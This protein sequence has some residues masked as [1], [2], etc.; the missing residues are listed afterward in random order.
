M[1]KPS[2]LAKVALLLMNDG[3]WEGKQIYPAWYIKEATSLQT[4]TLVK[5]HTLEEQQGY[6]YQFWRIRN[7]NGYMCYGK[8]GQLM[9]CCPKYDFICVTTAD[10][11]D[12]QG[13]TQLI[14]DS[15]FECILERPDAGGKR[16]FPDAKPPFIRPLSDIG[17]TGD[18]ALMTGLRV[19][20]TYLVAANYTFFKEF[21][22]RFSEGEGF[23][24]YRTI[25]GTGRLTF[26][27]QELKE[28]EFPGYEQRY[29]ASAVWL[30]PDMLF[31]VIHILGEEICTIR[32]QLVFQREKITVYMENTG[33][34]CFTE[35]SGCY[36]AYVES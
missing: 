14:C 18:S 35:F 11:L 33:E 20:K 31:A 30:R 34:F 10:C 23:F 25:N 22:V 17:I 7:E 28:G 5:G 6:G 13:G 16:R 26:G 12:I 1:A 3:V 2:D 9:I 24:G 15:L 8:G 32:I 4:F 19:E 27:M 21:Y 29:G 36:T